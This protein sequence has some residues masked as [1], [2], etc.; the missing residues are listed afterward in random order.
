MVET[1]KSNPDQPSKRRQTDQHKQP[2][3]QVSPKPG[4]QAAQRDDNE[5]DG[6]EGKLKQGAVE[7]G[8][9]EALDE[10][11]G[12][13]GHAAVDDTGCYADEHQ[14]PDLW[15]VK[16]LHGLPHVQPLVLDANHVFCYAVDGDNPLHVGQELGL[17]GGVRHKPEL[18]ETR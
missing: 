7:A 17:S 1:G 10:R 6:T 14:T 4:C 15:V 16:H 8:K 2:A 5:L 18:V 12:E 13:V 11:R 3:P 9:A